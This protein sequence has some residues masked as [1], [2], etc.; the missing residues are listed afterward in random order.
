[1]P[2]LCCPSSTG[3][4]TSCLAGGSRC[5]QSAGGAALSQGWRD[6]PDVSQRKLGAGHSHAVTLPL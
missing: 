2:P 4:V 1:M 3:A 5:G 6:V